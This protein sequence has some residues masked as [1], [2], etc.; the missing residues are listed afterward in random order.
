[1]NLL[2]GDAKYADLLELTMYN[3]ALAGISLSGDQFFY[4]NPLESA[5][6]YQRHDW[7]DPPCCPTNL[8]RF[9]PEIGSTIYGKS[10]QAI[11]INQFIGSEAKIKVS[12]NEVVLKQE[13][14]FPWGGKIS[15]TVDPEKPASLRLHI[16]IPGWAQ[17]KL[18]PGGL[19]EYLGDDNLGQAVTLKVNGEM[20]PHLRMEKG[21]SVIDRKW[22]KGDKVELDLP[23]HV[24]L[25]EGNP[26]IA[27]ARGKVVIMRGPLVYCLEEMDNQ[28]YFT[29]FNKGYLLHST[30]KE[31]YNDHLLGGVVSIKGFTSF[32]G[33]E[34][35]IALSAIPYFAWCNREKGQ[36]K[37]WLPY[38]KLESQT[39]LVT[40]LPFK[41][42]TDL[43]H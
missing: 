6:K 9:L 43:Y 37:V 31:E 5:G 25:V 30:F 32:P 38:Q 29:D 13:T 41:F 34:E 21:Y 27:D 40:A 2:T 20:I 18:L 22:K 1:M 42:F 12:G 28:R 23:M 14:D 16:R 36:M 33:N 11:F 4:T 24:R 8:V 10:D 26:R 35:E 17:G 3:A 15:L 19:Y 7:E 39:G